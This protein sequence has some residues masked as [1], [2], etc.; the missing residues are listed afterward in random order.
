M[1]KR[2]V[3]Q[4]NASAARLSIVINGVVMK[5]ATDDVSIVEKRL[6]GYACDIF[7]QF[8]QRYLHGLTYIMFL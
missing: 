1:N 8:Y 7:Q 4:A 5:S 3:A 2:R 6:Y